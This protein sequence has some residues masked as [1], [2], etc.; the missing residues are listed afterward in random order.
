MSRPGARGTR[1]S[2]VLA[3]S[4]EGFGGT[5]ASFS[6]FLCTCELAMRKRSCCAKTAVFLMFFTYRR[7][8]AQPK[9]RRKI[10]EAACQ[11]QVPSNSVLKISF[12]A[13]RA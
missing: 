2:K 11:T 9:K 13:R 10:V 12:G 4:G 8:R 7:F 6:R 1:F 5:R 3:R